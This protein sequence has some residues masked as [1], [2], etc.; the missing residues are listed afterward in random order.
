MEA[1][2][3]NLSRR[4][5]YYQNI[6]TTPKIYQAALNFMSQTSPCLIPPDV[7][8]ATTLRVNINLMLVPKVSNLDLGSGRKAVFRERGGEK[9]REKGINVI[10]SLFPHNSIFLP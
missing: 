7:A 6:P 9:V 5:S 8:M 3:L 10:S 4:L 2:C 1:I